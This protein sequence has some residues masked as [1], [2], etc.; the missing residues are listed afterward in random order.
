[1]A[2]NINNYELFKKRMF[3]SF[4]RRFTILDIG[5]NNIPHNNFN[6]LFEIVKPV[7]NKYPENIFVEDL[8]LLL[9]ERN[10]Y[11]I[12]ARMIYEFIDKIENITNG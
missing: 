1:M 12:S 10:G 11:S 9:V 3:V 5:I 7:L 2:K 6:N 4:L 8:I